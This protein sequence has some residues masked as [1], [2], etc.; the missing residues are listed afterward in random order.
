MDSSIFLEFC[1]FCLMDFE[2][3]IGAF[4][5]SI[6][7]VLEEFQEGKLEGRKLEEEGADS[8]KAFQMAGHRESLMA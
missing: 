5:F 6:I 2:I 8:P 1:Q 4:T 3:L 7:I